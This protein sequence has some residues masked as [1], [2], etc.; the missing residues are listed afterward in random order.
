MV[1]LK[2]TVEGCGN[3]GGSHH[4]VGNSGLPGSAAFSYPAG[5]S[6]QTASR[7]INNT[8]TGK[9]STRGGRLQRESESNAKKGRRLPPSTQPVSKD[10]EIFF[11]DFLEPIFDK[12][13]VVNELL[14]ASFIREYKMLVMGCFGE[15]YAFAILLVCPPL[16][17]QILRH[18]LNK[19]TDE[20]FLPRRVCI[21]QL[22]DPHH[23]GWCRCWGGGEPG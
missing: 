15:K 10:L 9:Q 13:C 17:Q 2:M 19:Q 4:V 14:N 1:L 11:K 5:F 8:G 18:F 22:W 6:R 21:W 3:D 20:R 7:G 12:I 23:V 16:T